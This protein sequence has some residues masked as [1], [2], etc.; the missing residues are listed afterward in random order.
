MFTHFSYA[1]ET[2]WLPEMEPVK[3]FVVLV[4][5][6]AQ[7]DR[8]TELVIDQPI[9][10]QGVPIRYLVDDAWYDMTPFPEHIRVQVAQTI[11]RMAGCP[12]PARYPVEGAIDELVTPE[13]YLRWHAAIAVPDAPIRLRRSIALHQWN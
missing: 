3:K 7:Q 12:E 1:D 6:Q 5:W 4:L 10:Q 11:I 2:P 9:P 8:A 13:V